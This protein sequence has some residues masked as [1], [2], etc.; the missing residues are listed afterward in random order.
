MQEAVPVGVGAMAALL[1]LDLPAV[2]S[3]CEQA[4]EGQVVSPANLN[5]SG[6]VVIAGHREAVER[7]VTLAKE[8]GAKRAIMLAGERAVSLCVVETC[9][10]P[11]DAR[12]R[13]LRVFGSCDFRWSRTS[14]RSRF[15]PALKRAALEAAGVASGA[16]AGERSVDAG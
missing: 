7:A 4:A 5:S 3:V 11:A 12:S 2:Q 6:Q 13:C 14:M 9:R 1:G 8:A 15:E 10:G 16:L